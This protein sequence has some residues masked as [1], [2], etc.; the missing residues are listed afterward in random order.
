[1]LLWPRLVC[2]ST[3]VPWSSPG[4]RLPKPSGHWRLVA[5]GPS[6][7]LHLTWSGDSLY[8]LEVWRGQ[9]YASSQWLCVFTVIMPAKCVCSVS[10]RFLYRRLTFCFLPLATILESPLGSLESGPGYTVF[11]TERIAE[12]KLNL[13]SRVGR[14]RE[15]NWNRDG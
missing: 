6:L 11:Q 5:Q 15:R 3:A 9:S 13:S 10:P 1:M 14:L 12:Q 2:G 8:Q 7:F 4:L